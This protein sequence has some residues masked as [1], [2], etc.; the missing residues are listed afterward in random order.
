MS[1]R[2]ATAEQLLILVDR[3][4]RGALTGAE[5]DRLRAGITRLHRD[6]RAADARLSVERGGLRQAAGRLA[7]LEGVVRAA[8]RRS[9]HVVT[10]RAL[11]IALGTQLA[12]SHPSGIAVSRCH[13]EP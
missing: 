9:A 10:I 2:P 13:S 12:P 8:R 3:A 5:A 1:A 6:R 11:D 7:A 4:E